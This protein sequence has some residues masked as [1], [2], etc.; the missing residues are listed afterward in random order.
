MRITIAIASLNKWNLKQLDIK[1]AYL[2]ADLN[3]KIY[4]KIPKVDRNYNKNKEWLLKKAL[5]G[6]KQAGRMW[7]EEITNFL[8]SI[9]LKQYKSDKCLFGKYNKENKLI[10]LLTLYVDDILI[11]GEDYKI[12]IIINKLKK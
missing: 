12:K 1:A 10:G 8:K 7:N 9:G 4:I 11:T 3:E 2:N 6:L 5:Y